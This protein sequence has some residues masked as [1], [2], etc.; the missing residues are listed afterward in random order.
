M[1]SVRHMAAWMAGQGLAPGD[2]TQRS[3]EKY[4]IGELKRRKGA[5]ALTHYNSLKIFWNWHSDGNSPIAGIK[6]PRRRSAQR[7]PLGRA[8]P[9]AEQGQP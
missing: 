6:A 4:L 5:G 8:G 1:T 9:C 3:L 7:P 2:V